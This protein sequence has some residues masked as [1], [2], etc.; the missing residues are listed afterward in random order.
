MNPSS[1]EILRLIR[2]LEFEIEE[3][4][5]ILAESLFKEFRKELEEQYA[6]KIRL[7]HLKAQ[8]NVEDLN[9]SDFC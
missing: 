1:S 5:L 3:Y 2:D 7:N 4:D 9:E 8:R 6:H